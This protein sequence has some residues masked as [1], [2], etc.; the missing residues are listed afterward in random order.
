M[1]ETSKHFVLNR[2]KELT[3][4]GL[5]RILLKKVSLAKLN[6]VFSHITICWVSVQHVLTIGNAF[7][8]SLFPEKFIYESGKKKSI[9][10]RMPKGNL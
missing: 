7:N 10:E 6:Q 9:S 4:K 1:R 2:M 8:P 3:A 5:F